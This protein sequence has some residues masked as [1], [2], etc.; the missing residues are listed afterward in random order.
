MA[1]KTL[2]YGDLMFDAN[3]KVNALLGPI[4]RFWIEELDDS[5]LAN[6]I[7]RIFLFKKTLMSPRT[8]L[9]MRLMRWM[10]P[11]RL[12]DHWQ[13]MWTG[14]PLGK[15]YHSN[16]LSV[17]I[18]NR[19]K[20]IVEA[21]VGL[22]AGNK[23]MAYILDVPPSD[24]LSEGD[25][26]QA[27]AI[28]Q[29]INKENVRIGYPVLYQQHVTNIWSLGRSWRQ[30][31][32][33][34]D[35]NT[36]QTRILWPGHCLSFWQEDQMT[37]EQVCV[38]TQMSV[39]KAVD[40]YPD[41]KEDIL[42]A[43]QGPRYQFGSYYGT[44]T[45]YGNQDSP[46]NH[47]TMLSFWYRGVGD[48]NGLVRNQARIGMVNVLLYDKNLISSSELA[49]GALVLDRIPET[50]YED[51]PV[52]CTPRFKIPDKPYDEATGVLMDL[53]PLNTE[54]NELMC[55]ARDM[56]WRAIYQRYVAKGF[57]FRNAPR[58]V[59]GTNMYVLP[60]GDQDLRRL[61]DIVNM[62]PVEGMITRLEE[63]MITIPGLTKMFIDG[64]YGEASGEAIDRAINSS[65]LRLEPIRT[66]IGADEEWMYRQYMAQGEAFGKWQVDGKTVRLAT[67]I[68]GKRDVHI[69]WR[70]MAPKD[71]V[72]AKQMALAARAAGIMSDDSAMDEWN[73]PSKTDELRKIRRDR[74]DQVLHPDHVSQT[75][76]AIIEMVQAK[77]AQKKA[78]AP[79]QQP[80]PDIKISLTGQMDPA[81]IAAAEASAGITSGDVSYP[82]GVPGAPMPSGPHMMPDGQMMGAGQTPGVVP[83]SGIPGVG[84]SGSSS[85]SR[86]REAART[87]TAQ[88]TPQTGPAQNAR[89]VPSPKQ[90][91]T[92]AVAP[93]PPGQEPQGG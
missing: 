32:T 58:L 86:A 68:A 87:A 31:L 13:S 16:G 63:A 55:A 21:G 3:K 54:L 53:A 79:Q 72:K 70:D 17:E 45:G 59:P 52:R 73:Y 23:P 65:I 93:P 29:W 40:L 64:S 66:N 47:V 37:L 27:D 57:T 2:E 10:D 14:K 51:I 15:L 1:K 75:A 82:G 7:Q 90:Q 8:L 33:D 83:S 34:P 30:T 48:K 9:D 84:A 92:A 25:I 42:A 46:Y 12:S 49:Q 38:V 44:G 41:K 5:D 26:A 50:G 78:A 69:T 22:L 91:A 60:R 62:Q 4:P 20:P 11:E 67:L 39:G 80:Q 76:N 24:V 28:E 35:T 85:G 43:V 88:G 74:Q 6:E 89:G 56:L 77:M 61:D 81:G 19:T 71:G 18:F 36:L